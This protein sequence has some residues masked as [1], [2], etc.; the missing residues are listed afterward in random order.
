MGWGE[1]R[2]AP[3]FQ[4]KNTLAYI[5][6]GVL[7]LTNFGPDAVVVPAGEVLATTQHD[8]TIERELEHDNTVWIKL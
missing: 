3:E 4:D 7:V 8:L 1:F 5:N 2:W 6:N